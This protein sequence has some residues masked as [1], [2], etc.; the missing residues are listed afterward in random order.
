MANGLWHLQDTRYR[1]A[2]DRYDGVYQEL[3]LARV[4]LEFA[5]T[6]GKM[7]IFIVR[8]HL[9]LYHHWIKEE[10]EDKQICNTRR[11][12]YRESRE[13]S[14]FATDVLDCP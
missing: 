12:K 13:K 5:G 6:A 2:F 14:C 7:F 4:R 11:L 3:A 10:R 1:N 8:I 9:R